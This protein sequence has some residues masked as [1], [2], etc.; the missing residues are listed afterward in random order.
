MTGTAQVRF[1]HNIVGGPNVKVYIGKQNV[2]DNLSYDELTS[3]SAYPSGEYTVTIRAE[4]QV[5]ITQKIKLTDNNNYTVIIG[6]SLSDNNSLKL[7]IYK[8]ETDCAKYGCS[9]IRFI[10]NVFGAPAVDVYVNDKIFFANVK[11]GQTGNPVYKKYKLGGSVS[12]KPILPF[13]QVRV[14][15]AGTGTNVLGPLPVYIISG[16]IYTIFA[17]GDLSA[18]GGKVS[19]D[20]EN[21]CTNTCEVLQDNFDI[22]R[23]MGKWFQIASIPQFYEAGCPRQTALYTFLSN[24]VKV[25]NTC[26][27]KNWE[28]VRTVTG[29][30]VAPSAC[31]PAALT[32][33][34]DEQPFPSPGPNYLIHKTDYVNYAIVGSPTRDSYYI[35]S[36]KSKI[37]LSEYKRFVKYAYKLGYN[38]SLIRPNYHTIINSDDSY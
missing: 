21:N 6:G 11:Y 35:L 3:Y 23:Y 1:L 24:K 22:Q 12:D 15:V 19:H 8:D 36:R 7:F 25:F 31:I 32:V 9:D 18:I 28:V 34:F 17:V 20:N 29:S 2:V 38:S 14:T 5:V 4:K 16:G 33:S 27:D 10:H 26:Y 37:S 13:Q 30:A